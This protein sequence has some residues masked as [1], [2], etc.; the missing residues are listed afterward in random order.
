MIN[1]R[2]HKR[3]PLAASAVIEFN[4]D[5]DAERIHVMIADI[6][7]SG[8]GIYSDKKIKEG[9]D[10]SIEINFISTEGRMTTAAMRGECIYGREIGTM[11]FIGI[12]FD[13]ELTSINQQPL[14]D[15]LQKILS[16]DK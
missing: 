8:I 13:E 14:Y 9:T 4:L 7:L 10:L 1:K 11:Y 5:A 15:H 12:E 16:S 2:R 6:S 3:V